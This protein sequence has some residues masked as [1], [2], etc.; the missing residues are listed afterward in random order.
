MQRRLAWSR[1]DVRDFSAYDGD[2]PA[3]RVYFVRGGSPDNTYWFWSCYGMH[4]GSIPPAHGRSDARADAIS[5]VE[6]AWFDPH[7]DRDR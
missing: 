6:D 5:A 3:G 1:S 7:R 4:D 2:T